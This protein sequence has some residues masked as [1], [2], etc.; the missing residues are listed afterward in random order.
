MAR[1]AEWVA[2]HVCGLSRDAG[3][4][5]RTPT[6][7]DYQ[8]YGLQGL[9][10]LAYLHRYNRTADPAL[11]QKAQVPMIERLGQ[12]FQRFAERPALNVAGITFSYRQ[13][14]RQSQAIQRSLQPLL[15]PFDTT[16]VV[17]ICLGKSLDLYAGI[18]AILSC[19][20]VYLP[21]EPGHPLRRQQAMLENARTSV[22]L[23][24]G[25]HPLREHFASLDISAIDANSTQLLLRHRPSDDAPCMV[26][27]TSGTTG[28]PKGVM[29]SQHNLAHF[30]AWIAPMYS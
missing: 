2:L 26:L 18:L 21:L 11:L 1:L 15:T 9:D 19:G 8:E 12:S 24:D 13:L 30:T 3:Y 10:S 16:P 27:Y 20:A 4:F 5:S 23:D 7:H 14:H 22:L 6:A 25:A 17:A 29:L 28:Q